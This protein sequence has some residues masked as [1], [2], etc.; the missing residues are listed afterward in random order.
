MIKNFILKS[1]FPQVFHLFKKTLLETLHAYRVFFRETILKNII[2]ISKSFFLSEILISKCISYVSK[3]LLRKLYFKDFVKLIQEILESLFQKVSRTIWK[4]KIHKMI[5][6][7]IGE[8]VK[9]IVGVQEVKAS[10][11]LKYENNPHL[12][13]YYR[14]IYFNVFLFHFFNMYQTFSINE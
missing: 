3:I 10:L 6:L 12:S 9:N 7:K 2:C 11:S 1:F 13:F 14:A 4:S 8:L 5:I